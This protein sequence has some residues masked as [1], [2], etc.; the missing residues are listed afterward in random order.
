MIPRE[1]RATPVRGNDRNLT[2]STVKITVRY[3]DTVV[4]DNST[5]KHHSGK[6]VGNWVVDKLSK[7]AETREE[8][9]DNH[10]D[11]V[12]AARVEPIHCK[13]PWPRERQRPPTRTG[14]VA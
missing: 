13:E 5:D 3:Y 14:L 10:R 4:F 9:M 12:Y 11:A 1:V 7:R 8:A 6:R 2:V